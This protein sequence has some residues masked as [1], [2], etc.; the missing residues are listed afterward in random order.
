MFAIGPATRSAK[1]CIE[2]K[3][4]NTYGISLLSETIDEKRKQIACIV[5]CTRIFADY[6]N[7]GCLGFWFVQ[8]VQIGAKDGN[9]TFIGLRVFAENILWSTD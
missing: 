8:L 7:Q 6:P 5:N 3:D 2:T 9:D 4:L 1:R